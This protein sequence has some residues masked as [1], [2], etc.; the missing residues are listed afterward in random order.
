MPLRSDAL[1]TEAMR[2]LRAGGP[3]A[4]GRRPE[5]G[6]VPDGE[7]VPCRQCLRHVPAG[8]FCP[9]LAHRPLAAIQPQAG[10][11]PIFPC[12]DASARRHFRRRS[13]FGAERLLPMPDHPS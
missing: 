3:D 5:G 1:P 6:H 9:I 11:G 4:Y 13:P 7:G 2:A 8:G 10:T 12:A